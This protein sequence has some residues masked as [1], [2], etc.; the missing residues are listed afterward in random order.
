MNG[1]VEKR[2]AARK[3]KEAEERSSNPNLRAGESSR[4]SHVKPIKSD[5]FQKSSGNQPARE[6]HRRMLDGIHR[7][8]EAAR[9][10]A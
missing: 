8:V 5:E 7:D 3:Q 9:A 10:N 4:A 1:E 6:R 2:D